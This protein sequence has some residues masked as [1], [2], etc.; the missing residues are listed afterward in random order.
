MKIVSLLCLAIF[1]NAAFAA[2]AHLRPKTKK[3]AKTHPANHSATKKRVTANKK[4]TASHKKKSPNNAHN[5]KHGAVKNHNPRTS[6][7]H[8]SKVHSK[9][10]HGVSAI[11]NIQEISQCLVGA[12][13]SVFESQIQQFAKFKHLPQMFKMIKKHLIPLIVKLETFSKKLDMQGLAAKNA[14]DTNA[15]QNECQAISNSRK[16]PVNVCIQKFLNDN[17]DTSKI[18]DAKE[19]QNKLLK[20]LMHLNGVQKGTGH[21]SFLEFEAAISNF[22]TEIDYYLVKLVIYQNSFAKVKDPSVRKMVVL[23]KKVSLQLGKMVNALHLAVGNLQNIN[24]SQALSCPQ[25]QFLAALSG[26][27]IA[28]NNLNNGAQFMNQNGFSTNVGQMSGVNNSSLN[29]Q[30]MPYAQNS[31]SGMQT[32]TSNPGY[33][34]NGGYAPQNQWQNVSQQPTYNYAQQYNDYGI[35]MNSGNAS[36]APYYSQNQ[37]SIAQNN[38]GN[39]MTPLGYTNPTASQPSTTSLQQNRGDIAGYGSGSAGQNYNGGQPSTASWQQNSGGQTGYAEEVKPY[40]NTDYSSAMPHET[41]T[42]R[43]NYNSNENSF[44]SEG[45]RTEPHFER[46]AMSQKPNA[47]YSQ[48]SINYPDHYAQQSYNQS[49]LPMQMPQAYASTLPSYF[50][51]SAFN[52]ALIQPA[53]NV[54]GVQDDGYETIMMP[55]QINGSEVATPDGQLLSQNN[56]QAVVAQQNT[57][58]V[59]Q[60]NNS[61][62]TTDS[63]VKQQVLSQELQK[64]SASLQKTE[65][66]L[67]Q[68]ADSLT[69]A[70]VRAERA[71]N[72]AE[73]AAYK[74]VAGSS[75]G[76]AKKKNLTPY[77]KTYQTPVRNQQNNRYQVQ[78]KR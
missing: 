5:A 59:N 66:E 74:V 10:A 4:K 9:G 72:R 34:P 52:P 55:V 58:V 23:S 78:P 35:G 51:G 3:V 15:V 45:K 47:F 56:S 76:Q 21:A 65:D 13:A 43:Q 53:A 8:A 1:L 46:D 61:V 6:A 28:S 29:S 11:K 70:V 68:T 67:E 41:V 25:A 14:Q 77:S 26:K 40:Q 30:G 39:T 27:T 42:S 24:H 37:Q 22:M 16:V 62:T 18:V 19:M 7:N 38:S 75:V 36:Q 33:N 49:Y 69:K 50:N 57:D 48:Q 73:K 71:A 63:N 31:Y 60:N 64:V 12:E 20:P 2:D 17:S 54:L 44:Y 32:S